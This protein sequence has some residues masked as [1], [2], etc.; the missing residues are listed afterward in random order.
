MKKLHL[1]LA[2]LLI[3]LLSVSA[4]Y[5]GDSKENTTKENTT[6]EN[7]TKEASTKEDT[8]E[9]LN[10]LGR[11]I[12]KSSK[13][14]MEEDDC[15]EDIYSELHWRSIADTFPDH[16]DLRERGTVTPVKD[17][18]PWGTCWSFAAIAASETSILNSLGMSAEEFREKSKKDMDLS[19]KHLSWFANKALPEVNEYAEGE[20]PYDPEQ[21]GEGHQPM[22]D[23]E[24]NLMKWGGSYYMAASSLAFGIGAL[25]EEYAPYTDS[26]GKM[27]KD[28]DWSLPE[29]MR[30]DFNY[31]LKDANVLP[32]P[33]STDEKGEEVYRPESTEAIKSELLAGRAVAIALFTDQSMPEMTNEERRKTLQ[34]NLKDNTLAT[35]DEKA[36]YIDLRTGVIDPAGLTDEEVEKALRLRLRINNLPEDTYDYESLDRDQMIRIFNSDYFS[37]PYDEIVENEEREG[38]MSFIGS[39][40]VIYAQYAN[41]KVNADH[42]VTIVGWDDNFAADNWPEDRRPSGDG[43]WIAKNSWGENWGNDGYFLLSYYDKTICSICTFE[44]D[45]SADNQQMDHL[46]ILGY[47]NM[48]ALSISSTLFDTPVYA[49]NIFKTKEDCVLQCVSAMT[50]DMDTTVTVSLYLLD[51]DAKEPTDGRLLRSTTETFKFAGY[52]KMDLNDNLLIPKDARIGIVILES[53][54]VENGIKYALVNTGN[55][56]KRGVVTYNKYHEED[57]N[58]KNFYAKGIVNPGE[59]FVCDE[60]GKWTDWTDAIKVIGKMGYNVNMAFDN[61]PIKAYT[62]PKEQVEKVHDL[63]DRIHTNDGEVAICP[64]DGYVLLDVT[65]EEE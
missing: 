15:S 30:Y 18:S 21:A 48:P 54:P 4:V 55:Y 28:G 53:V 57:G 45:I 62:Y 46:S 44:Y 58:P 2:V 17:Q 56:N 39:D 40:P 50:G 9:W 12:E 64:E 19:E 34:D 32:A 63:S 1:F 29:E 37:L 51:E 38:C 10:Y 31:E 20:Y 11:E 36:W 42:G 60:S 27:E 52:H 59:S 47:D 6:K 61:L 7:S 8:A 25:G 23:A 5:A 33:V 16:F 65:G 14:L 22:K 43:V 49:A 13:I 3:S 41:E 26:D 24:D 35:E